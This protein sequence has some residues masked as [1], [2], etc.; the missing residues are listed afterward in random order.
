M[1]A[2]LKLLIIPICLTSLFSCGGESG[3]VSDLIEQFHTERGDIVNEISEVAFVRDITAADSINYLL[4]EVY[5][6]MEMRYNERMRSINGAIQLRNKAQAKVN[7]AM[8]QSVKDYNQKDVNRFNSEIK[9]KSE[10]I[11]NLINATEGTFT[12]SPWDKQWKAVKRLRA[13]QSTNVV[14]KLYKAKVNIF[15]NKRINGKGQNTYLEYNYCINPE[16]TRLTV[17][18]DFSP[19]ALPEKLDIDKYIFERVK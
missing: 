18:K 9:Q 15:N 1:K 6:G 5:P 19:V 11:N 8:A 14:C 16:L 2:T 10:F 4:A 3:G 7:E 12:G 13:M 17:E